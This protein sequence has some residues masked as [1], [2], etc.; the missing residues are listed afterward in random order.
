MNVKVGENQF[1]LIEANERDVNDYLDFM[2]ILSTDPE[3][4]TLT[5]YSKLDR[6][7]IEE[8]SR[9][10]GK[11]TTLI[12][13][14]HGMRVAGMIQSSKGRYFGLERQA[15][16]AEVAYAVGKDFRGSG[17]IY[18]LFNYLLER[19]DVKIFTAWVDDRNAKSQRVLE[20]LGFTRCCKIDEFMYQRTRR[21]S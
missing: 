3:N 8:W 21:S 19:V 14:Y 7:R 17:L 15:H 4:Y 18:A 10:W 9:N 11:A 6:R 2:G 5:R 12:L 13:A 16:V 20:N 1:R